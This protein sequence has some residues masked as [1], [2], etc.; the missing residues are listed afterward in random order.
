MKRILPFVFIM[1][2]LA[3]CNLPSK[4]L[5]VPTTSEVEMATK[6]A[7][8]LTSMPSATSPVTIISP[9]SVLP[10]VKSTEVLAPITAPT[11]A[12]TVQPTTAPTATATPASTNAPGNTP[13]LSP[14]DPAARLG[15]AAWTD[16]MDNG[17]NWPV[18]PDKFTS[19]EF[20]DGSMRLT[21]ITTT[22]GWR[23]TWPNLTDFYIEM[24]VLA[25]SCTGTDRYGLMVR[26][27]DGTT[28]DRGY[29]FGFSCDGK[30][31]LR[32]WNASIGTKGEMVNLINWTSNTAIKAGPNQ[33]N[34]MG[35][36]AVGSRLILYANGQMLGEV[37][38]S[39]FAKG[40]FGVFV[41]ARE[42]QDMTIRVDQIRYWD[43][44][45][46]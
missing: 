39:T 20:K 33:T 8:I 16:N 41:G 17:D 31:S 32:R 10:T 24:T 14:S 18:G 38:D 25:P 3:G 12:P 5:P 36:M 4:A 37:K 34:K 42:T 46:P 29:L 40:F 35:L 23:L 13:T 1:I 26:V 45:T 15:S 7:Q 27:P 22:D 21:G 43:N 6:V 30:Y 28:P 9:T 44:P 2:L 19:L 11:L